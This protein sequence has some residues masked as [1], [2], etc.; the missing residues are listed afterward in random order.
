MRLTLVVMV[1]MLLT[2]S[3]VLLIDPMLTM[4]SLDSIQYGGKNINLF[5]FNN[6]LWIYALGIS[7]FGYRI[8]GVAT[9]GEDL[10][11][12]FTG[13]FNSGVWFTLY[14]VIIVSISLAASILSNSV[15]DAAK[16]A[17]LSIAVVS[18]LGVYSLHEY[19]KPTLKALY[20]PS[21]RSIVIED[22]IATLSLMIIVGTMF[23]VFVVAVLS[24]VLT[25][26]IL[27]LKP[28]PLSAKPKVS[29]KLAEKGVGGT[30]G[31]KPPPL[32]VQPICPRCG[33][34][35]VWKP[36]ESR[37]YCDK[38]QSYPEDVYLKI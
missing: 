20:G 10:V 38:C 7:P 12:A 22:A 15:S 34:K 4:L 24:G 25:H 8:E 11:K 21:L 31:V 27:M 6:S 23:N 19:L 1:L 2:L 3:P 30:E 37:Y 26:F 36:E 29:G 18:V 5:G 17:I 32:G 13:S 9:E 33:S 28:S 16:A 14:L 35:L